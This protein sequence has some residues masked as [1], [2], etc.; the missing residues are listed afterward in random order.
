VPAAAVCAA[1]ADTSKP[2]NADPVACLKAGD[3]GPERLDGAHD[4]VAGDEGRLWRGQ[5]T[6]DDVQVRS[7]DRGGGDLY[8]HLAVT[9][10]RHQP[11]GELQRSPFDRTRLLQDH[12]AHHPEPR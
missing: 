1:T 6:L 3:T 12:R 11:F 9:R 2:G 4:L 5:L 10:L 8:E 7:A